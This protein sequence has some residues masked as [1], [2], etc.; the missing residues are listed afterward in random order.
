MRR[1][2]IES[3]HGPAAYD[4]L[5]DL[6]IEEEKHWLVLKLI[7]ALGEKE[8]AGVLADLNEELVCSIFMR[9]GAEPE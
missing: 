8:I 5:Y 4:Q 3:V 2:D 1:S 9:A 6:Y 7:D